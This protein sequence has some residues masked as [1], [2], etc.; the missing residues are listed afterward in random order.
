MSMQTIIGILSTIASVIMAYQAVISL[1]SLARREKTAPAQRQNRFALV[2]CAR[3]EQAVIGHLLDSLFAQN[4]PRDKFD[5][6]VVADNCTDQTGAVASTAGAKV[7]TRHNLHRVGKGYALNWFFDRFLKEYGNRYDAVGI[8]DADNLVDPQFLNAMNEQ[9]CAGEVAAMGYRDSKNPHDSWVS[10]CM[11]LGF[12]TLSRFYLQPRSVLGLSAMAG[13]TGYVFKT[14]FIHDGWDTRTISEDTEFSMNLIAQGHRIAYAPRARFYDEQPVGFAASI[15]QRRRWASGTLQCIGACIPGLLKSLLRTQRD[16]AMDAMMFLL[17]IPAC[18][19]NMV[20]SI[21][22][23]GSM[24]L[25]PSFTWG[26]VLWAGVMPV[27]GGAL[28]IF[29]QG[30]LTLVLEKKLTAGMVKALLMYP[31]FLFTTG[32]CYLF[33]LIAPTIRWKPI[34]HRRGISLKQLERGSQP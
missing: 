11:S 23:F 2:V 31:F 34:E 30:F 26:P 18:A 15:R 1:A 20:L 10:G 8:F 16:I 5:V 27:L 21:L 9:L 32:L 4:Y 6:F 24:L 33:S 22:Q 13:G 17:L 3:N 25:S 7:Y 28:G 14:E 12:W 29:A 19:F